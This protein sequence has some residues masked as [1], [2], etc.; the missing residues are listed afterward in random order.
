MST[1]SQEGDVGKQAE[2]F[3][4]AEPRVHVPLLGHTVFTFVSR[5]FNNIGRLSFSI[6]C[7]MAIHG[8]RVL[9]V[10]VQDCPTLRVS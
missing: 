8:Q 10:V 6:Y 3:E 1:R 4:F 2:V 9:A 7:S 5:H